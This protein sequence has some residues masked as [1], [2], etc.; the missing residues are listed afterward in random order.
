M[1]N[2]WI[3]IH[4]TQIK[5]ATDALGQQIKLW[6]AFWGIKRP[7]ELMIWQ[8]KGLVPAEMTFDELM[9][10]LEKC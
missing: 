4:K 6:E 9:K 5:A 8:P 1:K 3:E 7:Q 10:D 2:P